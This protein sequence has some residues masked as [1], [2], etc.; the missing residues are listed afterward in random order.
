MSSRVTTPA[1]PPYLVD[2]DRDG[3][4]LRRRVS[5]GRT[6]E[7]L[8]DEQRRAGDP[9]GGGAEPVVRGYREGVLEVDHADDL[10][11][12]LPV[13]G[14]AGQAG[15]AGQVDHVL[16]GGRGLQGADLHARGHD[17]LR[18]QF[19][20]R[21]GPHEEVG[22]VPVQRAGPGGVPGQRDQFAGGCAR[23]PALRPVRS[24]GRGPGGWPRRSAR[25]SPGGNSRAKACCG[26]ATKRATCKGLDTAQ[27]LGTSSPIT[28]WTAEAS[29]M[30][31]DDGDARYG[32]FG[33]AGRGERAVQELASAGS[34]EHADDERGDGD[35]ELGAGELKDSSWRTR[36]PGGHAGLR[37]RR[38]L[39]VGAFDGHQAELR[40]ATKKPLARISRKG[41]CQEQQ[42]VVVMM[43][44]PVGATAGAAQVL[45]DDPS[46]AGGS[47]PS[48]RAG[49]PAR[50][51]R[52]DRGEDATAASSFP[53]LIT[54]R[55]PA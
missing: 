26:P 38:L 14:E 39:G 20:Q 48:G 35:A 29:S 55:V 33:D 15:G 5:S 41:G 53:R 31:D 40:G 51:G 11:D 6:G 19:A 54:K 37:R 17:V 36:R 18:G 47:H 2:D 8:G 34:G 13:D 9:A 45:Q 3:L 32:A 43:P 44:P 49:T 28:I 24:R 42:G 27:F 30:P 7:G 4:P 16:G 12:L 22:R 46:I 1:V 21:Q 25:R 10:V 50:T 52:S 23:R